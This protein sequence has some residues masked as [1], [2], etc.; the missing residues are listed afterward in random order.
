MEP[1]TRPGV[2]EMTAADYHRDPVRGGSLSS[3]GARRLLA[4]SC[5]AKFRYEQDHGRPDTAAFDLGRAAHARVLG[6]GDP[7]KV[8][9]GSGKD[10]NSW[11]TNAT[12]EAVAE[13]RAAGF[14]PIKPEDVD[15]IDA[16]AAAL[17]ADPYAAPLLDPS[18][19]KAEQVLVWRDAETG[20]WCR[21]MIDWLPQA[22]PGEPLVVTDYKTSS[23]AEPGAISRH[24]AD[25]G[26]AQQAA[27]YLDGVLAL[28]LHGGVLPAFKFIFQEK[29]APY[30]V[31]VVELADE[32]IDMGRL[33]NRKARDVYR[34][35][36]ESGRWPSYTDGPV[37]V[38]LPG[39]H[40]SRIADAERR[41]DYDIET[42]EQEN[43]A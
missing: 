14:T 36:V 9:T 3:T 10:P 20:V 39:W 4:P 7:V 38:E 42:A 17:R 1:I 5:P 29:T 43:A 34:Q 31:T 24:C 23:S 2:Y 8:I 40:R 6:V 27:W 35:C 28:D 26:Y 15:T 16:M 33:Q 18:D 37:R 12:K 30:L 13:A 19:G 21:A 41:G 25:F 22:W 32:D 11:N